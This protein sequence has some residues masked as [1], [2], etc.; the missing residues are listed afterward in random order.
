LGRFH[1]N[2]DW[3]GRLSRL[4]GGMSSQRLREAL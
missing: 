4:R 1:G 3:E 2:V